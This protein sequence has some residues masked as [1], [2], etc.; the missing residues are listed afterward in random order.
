MKFKNRKQLLLIGGGLILIIT[1][2]ILWSI[3]VEGDKN[4]KITMAVIEGSSAEKKAGLFNGIKEVVVYDD[5]ASL[6][7]ALSDG[8]VDAVLIDFLT[9]LSLIKTGEFLQLKL[10][11]NLIDREN[12]AIA[13]HKDDNALRQA[14]NEGLKK[15]IN[16]GAYAQISQKYFGLDILSKYQLDDSQL[17]ESK[18][19]DDSWLRVQHSGIITV[20]FYDN[21]WP[22]SYWDDDDE[23]TGFSVDIAKSVCREL[24]IKL[25]SILYPRDEIIAGLKNKYY[26]CIWSSIPST[27]SGDTAVCLSNP[28]YIS[29]LQLITKKDSKIRNLN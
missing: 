9:G 18:V 26:D 1:A 24:G 6:L 21:N 20:A 19:T 28:F 4:F 2:G 13:F 29:G 23:I 8:R 15:I 25:N 10:A 3:Q 14:I 5:E 11:G 17:R 7:D 27:D 22:F 12:T 16:N